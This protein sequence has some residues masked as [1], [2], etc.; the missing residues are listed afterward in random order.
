MSKQED[1]DALVRK[2]LMFSDGRDSDMRSGF[3][4]EFINSP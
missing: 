1:S 4:T 2:L 3:D